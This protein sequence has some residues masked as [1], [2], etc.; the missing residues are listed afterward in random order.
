MQKSTA[1]LPEE[2]F[3][4]ET[5]EEI[6]QK[7]ESNLDPIGNADAQIADEDITNHVEHTEENSTVNSTV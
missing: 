7:A 4:I 6:E 5:E 3:K 1:I 2:R